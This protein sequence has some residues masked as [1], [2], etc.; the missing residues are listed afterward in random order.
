MSSLF[1]DSAQYISLVCSLKMKLEDE[2]N[3]IFIHQ[4]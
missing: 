4:A 1:I 3:I 2:Y